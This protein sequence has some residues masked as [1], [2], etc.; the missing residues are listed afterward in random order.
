MLRAIKMAVSLGESGFNH[1]IQ[2]WKSA[3]ACIGNAKRNIAFSNGSD[4][5]ESLVQD[6]S[7][8]SGERM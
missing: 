1:W 7:C 2:R 4:D 6:F 5:V 8:P 3:V